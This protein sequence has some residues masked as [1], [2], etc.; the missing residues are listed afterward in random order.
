MRL[1]P[2]RFPIPHASVAHSIDPIVTY[3]IHRIGPK[4]TPPK[5]VNNTA[6]NKKIGLIKHARINNTGHRMF[7]LKNSYSLM[8]ISLL[9]SPVE[10]L[11]QKN[12]QSTKPIATTA[13]ILNPFALRR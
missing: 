9:V 8:I 7:Q 4:S 5:I 6:G 2:K 13:A 12:H 1:L 11:N 10:D 3:S